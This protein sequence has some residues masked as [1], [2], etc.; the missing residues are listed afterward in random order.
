[1]A[2]LD[3]TRGTPP[4]STGAGTPDSM[5]GTITIAGDPTVTPPAPDTTV[6]VTAA[7]LNSDGALDLA[8]GGNVGLP[9]ATTGS[10]RFAMSSG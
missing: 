8:T 5:A 7:D 1:M 2:T 9:D 6:T 10:L 3:I 4:S